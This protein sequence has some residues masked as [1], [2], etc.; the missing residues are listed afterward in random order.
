MLGSPSGPLQIVPFL[1]VAF[2]CFAVF[3][4]VGQNGQILQSTPTA[5][6]RVHLR[7]L[8]PPGL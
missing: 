2:I 4:S 1:L 3:P 5:N 7:A 6:I 8:D